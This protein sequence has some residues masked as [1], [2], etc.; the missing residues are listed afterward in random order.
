MVGTA[1]ERVNN[2]ADPTMDFRLSGAIGTITIDRPRQRNA[3]TRDMWETLGKWAQS[4]PQQTRVLIIGGRG[5]NFSAGSDIKEMSQLSTDE[6]NQAF[7]VI[8]WAISQIDRLPIPTIASI[9]GPAF[10]GGFIL[11][12]ACDVHIGSDSSKFGM[13]VGKLG[14]TLQPSFLRRLV[15]TIGPSRTKDM[16]YTAKTLE[17]QDALQWGVLNYLVNTG[18]LE[19]ETG[20]LARTILGQSKASLRAVKHNVDGIVS[21]TSVDSDD[22]VDALD[23]PEGIRAFI[24][25]RAAHF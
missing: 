17:A 23:F 25:K 9:N 3:L 22:W 1:A 16:V 15:R 18:D 5:G 6:A 21:G 2:P 8:E 12:L 7:R 24:E 14:I 11:A 4:M 10:G 20:R 19:Q 13:P